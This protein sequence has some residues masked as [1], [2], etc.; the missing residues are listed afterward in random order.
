M[1]LEKLTKLFTLL[2]VVCSWQ[3]LCS[4]KPSR[5][6]SNTDD[7]KGEGNIRR[8]R[9][10]ADHELS[11]RRSQEA[12][13]RTRRQY[14]SFLLNVAEKSTSKSCY[15]PRRNSQCACAMRKAL[16]LIIDSLNGDSTEQPG[17]KAVQMLV[18]QLPVQM[19]AAL[20]EHIVRLRNENIA[21]SIRSKRR[22][23]RHVNYARRPSIYY[24]TRRLRGKMLLSH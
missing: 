6:S 17:Q 19:K 5:S 8:R 2:M 4:A 24:H 9:S 3:A 11:N 12:L 18:D 23:L 10:V 14:L 21:K 7:G 20:A 22:Y 16:D 15:C 1:D 13:E